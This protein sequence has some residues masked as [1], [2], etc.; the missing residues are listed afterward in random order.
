MSRPAGPELAPREPAAIEVAEALGLVPH[1]EGG[2]FRET[3]RSAT[4]VSTDAGPR[5]LCTAI[6]YLLAADSPSRFHRLRSDEVW[7]FHAGNPAELFLLDRAA[8]THGGL[9]AEVEARAGAASTRPNVPA[10]RGARRPV[11]GSSGRSRH[12]R[13]GG[14]ASGRG[15]RSPRLD[16]GGLRRHARFRVRRLRTG[17]PRNV[18]AGV[19]WG[20]GYRPGSDLTP[21]PRRRTAAT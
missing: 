10:T 9:Q 12:A 7:F 6:V 4:S 11:A 14:Q 21:A 15:R 3:Y 19:P 5:P 13:R 17:R 1:R 20:S 2:F 18:G 8:E 16:L